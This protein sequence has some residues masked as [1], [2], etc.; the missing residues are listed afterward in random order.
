MRFKAALIVLLLAVCSTEA[1]ACVRPPSMLCDAPLPPPSFSI[2][3][4]GLQQLQ[5]LVLVQVSSCCWYCTD[6]RQK[7]LP[8][9]TEGCL[10]RA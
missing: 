1:V 4:E 9:V 3:L 10:C 5:L 2:P 7:A 8:E 6:H